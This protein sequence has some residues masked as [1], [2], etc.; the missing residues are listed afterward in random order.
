MPLPAVEQFI[1]PVVADTEIGSDD[2]PC[3]EPDMD[4]VIT[5]E[6][7]KKQRI[8]Y[9]E[10]I[11]SGKGSFRIPTNLAKILGDGNDAG[12]RDFNAGLPEQPNS[13]DF[14]YVRGYQCGYRMA[15]KGKVHQREQLRR[16]G[17]LNETP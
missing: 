6:L 8:Q 13:T 9:A 17:L 3:L 10:D 7:E 12:F 15:S 16:L 1:A 4:T 11:A 2:A 14:I 5:T